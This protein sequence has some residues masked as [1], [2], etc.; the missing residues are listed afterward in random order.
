MLF[1]TF[2]DRFSWGL[3][4]LT[5]V[6]AIFLQTKQGSDYLG[7]I[8]GGGRNSDDPQCVM[9]GDACEAG[10]L[11]C[12][13][14]N[15]CWM[16]ADQGGGFCVLDGVSSS[17]SSSAPSSASASASSSSSSSS[18]STAT[19][20][21]GTV[22][23]TEQCDGGPCCSSTCTFLNS[24]TVCR[25]AAGTCDAEEK[26]TGASASCPSDSFL[27]A[28][29]VCRTAAGVCD[30]PET[31]S[32]AS[33]GCPADIFA[34]SST[35]CRDSAGSCDIA[36]HCTGST[37]A[38]PSNSFVASTVQCRASQ[39][40]CDIAENCTGSA[41]QCP[42][43]AFASASVVCRAKADVC[44]I[45]ENCTGSAAACPADG[46]L[47]N[48]TSCNS[49][50]GSCVSGSCEALCGNG[51][52]DSGEQCEPPNV[53]NCNAQCQNEG[54][55]DPGDIAGDPGNIA[56]DP[57]DMGGDGG[58]GSEPSSSSRSSSSRS[59][60]KS[61]SS[62]SS[63]E[64]CEEP[65][66]CDD[67]VAELVIPGN[68]EQGV[69]FT[70]DEEKGRF[71]F[72]IYSP[73][74][75]TDEEY[76]KYTWA[77]GSPA[78]TH[79]VHGGSICG[80]VNEE[81][82]WGVGTSPDDPQ[83]VPQIRPVNCRDQENK[84]FTND[85]TPFFDPPYDENQKKAAN[86]ARGTSWEAELDED[87]YIDF[88]AYEVRNGAGFSDNPGGIHL[89]VCRLPS[90]K[91]SSSQS[92]GRTP[93]GSSGSSGSQPP[94][95]SQS[96]A[97]A[98]PSSASSATSA[99]LCRGFF[100]RGDDE[101]GERFV[102]EGPERDVTFTI[103]SPLNLTDI[104]YGAYTW[105]NGTPH[106]AKRNFGGSVLL[107]PEHEAVFGS[108]GI[109]EDVHE[110]NLIRN[111]G[112]ENPTIVNPYNGDQWQVYGGAAVL[113]A[114]N[115]ARPLRNWNP[116]HYQVKLHRKNVSRA[117]AYGLQY[118]EIDTAPTGLLTQKVRTQTG[119]T[120]QIRFAYAPNPALGAQSMGVRWNGAQVHTVSGEGQGGA[121]EWQCHAINV[122]ALRGTAELAFVGQS[123]GNFLDQ[124]SL[125]EL[126]EGSPV[127][128]ST[129][130]PCPQDPERRVINDTEYYW[131]SQTPYFDPPYNLNRTKAA[132]EARWE[133]KT[134]HM[135]HNEFV[136]LVVNE[137]HDGFDDN[138]GAVHFEV[139]AVVPSSSSSS[140]R[141]SSSRSSSSSVSVPPGYFAQ[142][143]GDECARGGE[144]ACALQNKTCTHISLLPCIQCI[145]PS[146]ASSI[147]SSS[148]GNSSSSVRPSSSAGV[149]TSSRPSS[150]N[151]VSS[152]ISSIAPSSS[153]SAGS[154]LSNGQ[155]CAVP[156]QCASGTCQFG[157]CTSANP[158]PS[159]FIPLLPGTNI[160]G[161]QLLAAIPPPS[162][163][164]GN[165]RPNTSEECDDGNNQDL[166][167][168]S[169]YCLFE[170]GTCGD[171]IVQSLLGE[172][173]EP[174]PQ[175]ILPCS[176]NCR[177]LL[178]NCGDGT[179]QSGEQ[180]DDGNRNSN[181]PGARCRPD[182]SPGRC[183]DYILDEGEECDDGNRLPGDTCDAFCR[184]ERAAATGTQNP[185]TLPA[186]IVD[187]PFTP[188]YQA[189]Q[190]F[191]P[192]Y[193][194]ST[195]TNPNANLPNVPET[196]DSG[197]EALAIMAS[198]A[199]AG[200]AWMRRRRFG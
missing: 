9:Q 161:T 78:T 16:N 170:R 140:R 25:G 129:V 132:N 163:L 150:S 188:T 165:D 34:L 197:P 13:P 59:S 194:A 33:V 14:G 102:N 92:S 66:P 80:L 154:S 100:V 41:A 183:G 105:A 65:E 111:G 28:G 39:G 130:G 75:L 63:A 85:E 68:S 10:G 200:W 171:R 54:G 190:Q 12:C 121:V 147:F 116:E 195:L 94:T 74:C 21:N 27:S 36:E 67:E 50:V 97:S 119:A 1:R 46:F 95:G 29:S 113:G 148:F 189:P 107:V 135:R 133:Q 162:P 142:C 3:L 192:T 134:L 2:L 83:G 71:S 4:T 158:F 187:L 17:S 90:N 164:C 56:G 61:S 22:E 57:G 76:A 24:G 120:Y 198:G 149:A 60:S 199:A 110:E 45:A 193:T 185:A 69:R 144:A 124:V 18:S 137:L 106:T 15:S 98:R 42:A 169:S 30:L 6:S 32:G 172:Q 20:G 38:C 31:C 115:P 11:P 77:N 96:S 64:S 141:S 123:S 153:T 122:P 156:S 79:R 181:E 143:F 155:L 178:L 86:A 182:C 7:Q 112:F 23:G 127:S 138:T 180:C 70:N 81:P 160:P 131:R 40:V 87:G 176:D 196:T 82:V 126:P 152:V 72:T 37:A 114:Y 186:T 19:C 73:K 89:K 117:P 88:L 108:G 93:G 99:D 49:G 84:I 91:S 43:D 166:D 104:Q 151:A 109:R 128:G 175:G 5:L 145:D 136:T 139:C 168:C 146:G 179:M 26:C 62:S 55:V 191:Q 125:V 159:V 51:A 8:M 44:D 174:S 101:D 48:G 177:F 35:I 103:V 184:R 47:S 157:I 52:I 118:A 58:D 173:C 53:G 167:G